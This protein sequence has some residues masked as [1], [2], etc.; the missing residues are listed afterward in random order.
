MPAAL[1]SIPSISF[2]CFRG[3]PEPPNAARMTMPFAST[4]RWS[5]A[6][7]QAR[8]PSA[9]RPGHSLTDLFVVA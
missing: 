5:T 9:D 1:C 7:D 2:I 3:G 8:R 6:L 4:S